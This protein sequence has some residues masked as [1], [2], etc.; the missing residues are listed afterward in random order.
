MFAH[1]DQ[2]NAAIPAS[3]DQKNFVFEMGLM[4]ILDVGKAGDGD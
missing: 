1:V 2:M 3:A 4:G